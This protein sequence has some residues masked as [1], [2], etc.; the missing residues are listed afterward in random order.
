M[1]VRPYYTGA[2]KHTAEESILAL[3]YYQCIPSTV[4]LALFSSTDDDALKHLLLDEL[5]GGFSDTTP[6]QNVSG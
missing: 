6:Q 2:Q 5:G 4:M 3:G 1:A